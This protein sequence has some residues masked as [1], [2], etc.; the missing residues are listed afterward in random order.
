VALLIVVVAVVVA[1]AI[2]DIKQQRAVW[3]ALTTALRVVA[4]VFTAI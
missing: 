3:I 4:V 2:V 1:V